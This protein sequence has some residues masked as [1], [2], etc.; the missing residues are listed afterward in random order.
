MHAVT[1]LESAGGSGRLLQRSTTTT[2]LSSMAP[3]AHGQHRAGGGLTRTHSRGSSGGG[4][5]LGLSNLQ[6]TAKD[7]APARYPDKPKKAHHFEVNAHSRSGA[8]IAR[9]NSSVRLQ[10][11]EPPTG[12]PLRRTSGNSSAKGGSKS[13]PGFSIASPS[14]VD[15]DEWISSESGAATPVN[16]SDGEGVTPVDKPR[17]PPN[18]SFATG[19]AKDELPTPR[20]DVLI[21]PRI[22]TTAPLVETVQLTVDKRGAQTTTRE[23]SQLPTSRDSQPPPKSAPPQQTNIPLTD[24]LPAVPLTPPAGKARSETHSPPRR[25]P[26]ELKRSMTRPPSI[27]SIHT[28]STHPLRPHPLIRANSLGYGAVFGT[29]KPVPLAP[30]TT[31]PLNSNPAEMSQTSPTSMRAVSPT[32]SIH[33]SITSPVLSHP[34]PTVSEASRQLRRSSTS[35]RSSVITMPTGQQL[36]P[37]ASHA[38]L[39]KASGHDRQRTTSSSSTFAA[40]SSLNLGRRAAPSPSKAPFQQMIVHFPLVEETSQQDSIHPL[41]PSPYI[42]THL[43]MLQYRVPLAESYDRVMRAKNAR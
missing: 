5:R 12:P 39:T 31:V 6:L 27:N 32:L 1:N 38:R 21:L 17:F 16:D 40:L 35:S 42:N 15:D 19:F 18:T 37:S 4:S 13:K 24:S 33:G 2:S 8:H 36:Q 11:K 25:S 30:L 14:D 20:A 34:S 22:D 29:A 26:D 7:P 10:Q 28:A 43:T 3:K 41:L 9:N 23:P